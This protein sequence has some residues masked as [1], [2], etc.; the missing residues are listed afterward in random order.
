MSVAATRGGPRVP[1]PIEIC[2]TDNGPGAPAD[3]AEYLF[4]PFISGRP[5]GQ[6]LGLAL[7]DKLMRDMG[8]IVQYAREGL[9]EMTTLRLLL[10]R[11][12]Q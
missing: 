6:G 10:P 9:P 3:I 11:A 7:V 8:G 1:L 5:E 2:V 12:A 4:D